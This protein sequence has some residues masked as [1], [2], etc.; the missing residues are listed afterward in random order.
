MTAPTSKTPLIEVR[1]L[2]KY[3]PLTKGVFAR[4]VADVKA[5]DGL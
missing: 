5:V 1:D 3:F 2:V 4:K